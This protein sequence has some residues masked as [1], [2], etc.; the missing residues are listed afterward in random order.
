MR[1]LSIQEIDLLDFFEVEPNRP[2]PDI[3]WTYDNSVY[4]VGDSLRLF[5]GVTPSSKDVSLELRVGDDIL[6]ELSA[7][8]I[9]DVHYHKE[10]RRRVTRTDHLAKRI[11][12]VQS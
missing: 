7:L 5:F 8:G 11:C 12:L 1:P 2:E 3:P 10:K 4:E 9:E 6:Y